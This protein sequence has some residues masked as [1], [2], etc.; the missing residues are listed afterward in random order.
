MHW[1]R[2]KYRNFYKTSLNHISHTCLSC[3][4]IFSWQSQVKLFTIDELSSTYAVC[5]LLA[6]DLYENELKYSEI[7][8]KATHSQSSVTY[9][10][11]T[12]TRKIIILL[13]IVGKCYA[14]LLKQPT[15]MLSSCNDM[16]FM[17]PSKKNTPNLETFQLCFFFD[18][19]I[20]IF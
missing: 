10:C 6:N 14:I 20:F 8:L 11:Y 19:L 15:T 3:Q 16:N 9:F 17:R 4:P 1:K 7:Q 12:R 5:G 13:K 18:H 2:K